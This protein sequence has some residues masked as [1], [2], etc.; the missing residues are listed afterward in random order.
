MYVYD[1]VDSITLAYA[2]TLIISAA[3]CAVFPASYYVVLSFHVQTM[4]LASGE[5]RELARKL[6]YEYG[7]I[8]FEFMSYCT[9]STFYNYCIYYF[10]S[11]LCYCC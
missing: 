6:P 10:Y 2:C 11:F 1:F 4:M 5:G 3:I 7:K 8:Y 9:L